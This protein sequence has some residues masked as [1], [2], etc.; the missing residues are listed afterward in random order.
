MEHLRLHLLLWI[1]VP[2]IVRREENEACTE[3]TH[4]PK[5]VIRKP[6]A[7][8]GE[9]VACFDKSWFSTLF[10]AFNFIVLRC[11]VIFGRIAELYLLTLQPFL[12]LAAAFSSF[13]VTRFLCV[14]VRAYTQVEIGLLYSTTYTKYIFS[15]TSSFI[16]P[17]WKL[18][19]GRPFSLFCPF[20]LFLGCIPQYII[21]SNDLSFSP[22]VTRLYF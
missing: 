15:T 18:S 2:L 11:W 8:V 3:V 7:P 5:V 6:R 22:V 17:F 4:P 10:F 16:S 12:S 9:L 13:H 1:R 19:T 14:C 20:G 21:Y